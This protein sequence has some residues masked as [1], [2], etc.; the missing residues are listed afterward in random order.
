MNMW[1]C[2]YQD[3]SVVL[4]KA[5]VYNN[6]SLLCLIAFDCISHELLLLKLHAYGFSI[7]ELRLVHSDLKNR[8]QRTKMNSACSSWEEILFGVPQ[9]PILGPLPFNI[10]DLFYLM[11]DS[12]FSSYAT[13]IHLMAHLGLETASVNLFKWFAGSQMEANQNKCHLI[14]SKNENVSLYFGPFEI[15][16]TNC[17]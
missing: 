7:P 16:N 5:K 15:K 9:E 2:F 6:V 1:M 11:N 13:I 10:C 4:E 12:D 8:K 17:E 14:V 3:T